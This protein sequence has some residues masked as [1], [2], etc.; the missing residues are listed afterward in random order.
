MI[1]ASN[2]QDLLKIFAM[3][4]MIIDHLGL[5]FFPEYSLMRLIGRTAMPVFCFFA[6]Y[7]FKEQPKSKILLFGI[8]LYLITTILLKQFT[9]GNILISIYIGQCYLCLFRNKLHNIIVGSM[10]IVILGVLGPVTCF[11]SDYGSLAVAV[12][13]CGYLAAE[14][15]DEYFKTAV[16][17]SIIL[18]ILHTFTV[19]KFSNVYFKTIIILGA[20]E[21]FLMTIKTFDQEILL[22]INISVISRNMLFIYV[23]HLIIMQM[24]FF[25]MF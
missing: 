24:I 14:H 11:F 5:Y 20:L 23:F 3:I 19:F 21:Y 25:G 4:T 2:Y 9:A 1:T 12:M 6:G 16:F 10:H 22:N 13:V 8:L 15:A 17:I 7:N 18:S